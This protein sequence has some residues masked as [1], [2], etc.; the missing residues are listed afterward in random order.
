MLLTNII[1][2]ECQK[3]KQQIYTHSDIHHI[4]NTGE[5]K[6]VYIYDIGNNTNFNS[7]ILIGWKMKKTK[8]LYI[9][10]VNEMVNKQ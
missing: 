9:N 4:Y 1:N 2:T 8:D 10:I 3:C 7:S 5:T 6:H